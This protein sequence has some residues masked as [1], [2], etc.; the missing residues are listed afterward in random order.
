MATNQVP[1]IGL[2]TRINATGVP[3]WLLRENDSSGYTLFA[4][5]D[6]WH[7]YDGKYPWYTQT[8][9][10]AYAQHVSRDILRDVLRRLSLL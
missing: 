5:F 3:T 2:P 10:I 8:A 6:V 1:C 9:T 7:G 4:H